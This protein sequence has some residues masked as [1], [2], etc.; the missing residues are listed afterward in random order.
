[1]NEVQVGSLFEP[2]GTQVT[3]FNNS[4][5]DECKEVRRGREVEKLDIHSKHRKGNQRG[6]NMNN[7]YSL[8]KENKNRRKKNLGNCMQSDHCKCSGSV[9]SSDITYT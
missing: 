1:M 6:H 5:C 3:H 2:S 7:S 8:S 9:G 4:R